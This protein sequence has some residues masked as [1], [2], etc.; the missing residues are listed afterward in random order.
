MQLDILADLNY[1]HR[2]VY[3]ALAQEALIKQDYETLKMLVNKTTLNGE[4]DQ[5]IGQCKDTLLLVCWSER[6]GRN[7]DTVASV[8][9]KE[10]RSDHLDTWAAS[11][12]MQYPMLVNIILT[13]S[14]KKN[15][16]LLP[17]W[18]NK[19]VAYDQRVQIGEL[20]VNVLKTQQLSRRFDEYY[21]RAGY[22]SDP[23]VV[24]ENLAN[25]TG[26]QI[27]DNSYFNTLT[28]CLT[29]DNSIYWQPG[30]SE[31]ALTYFNNL[32]QRWWKEC[33][34]TYHIFLIVNLLET[35]ESEQSLKF[36]KNEILEKINQNKQSFVTRT[37]H[38]TNFI[39]IQRRHI[40]P[41]DTH[42]V[43][44]TKLLNSVEKSEP[45]VIT[46]LKEIS[47]FFHLTETETQQLAT[48]VW[49]H[50][51]ST[52]NMKAATFD[53]FSFEK[54]T[55]F[56]ETIVKYIDENDLQTWELF[57]NHTG[58]LYKLEYYASRVADMEKLIKKLWNSRAGYYT[59][60]TLVNELY[61]TNETLAQIGDRIVS[62]QWVIKRHSIWGRRELLSRV[63][64]NVTKEQMRTSLTLIDNFEGSLTDFKTVVTHL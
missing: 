17:L 50:P 41:T 30:K 44:V 16:L 40:L 18:Y 25:I 53:L 45:E 14:E 57:I 58:R 55:E 2:G 13:K 54:E 31:K 34:N 63:F 7:L 12:L 48:L 36:W 11:K 15:H 10:N 4:I 5:K 60:S 21:E 33:F 35:T 20:I 9:A 3:D 32:G 59:K 49:W 56:Y 27:C 1:T 39:Q 24:L 46:I 8:L 42:E 37:L 22:D 61:H 51:K 23:C 26:E 64:E 29:V 52:V 62:V 19:Y 38:N 6:T 28:D 47:S 43:M